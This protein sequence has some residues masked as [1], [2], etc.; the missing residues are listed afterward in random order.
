MGAVILD[1]GDMRRTLGR[2]A[3]EILE[4]NQGADSLVVVGVMKRG[5]PIDSDRRC[6]GPLWQA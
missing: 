2:M 5:W 3:H 1:A 4:N 6:H